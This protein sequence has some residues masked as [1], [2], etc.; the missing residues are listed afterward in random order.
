M[1][2]KSDHATPQQDGLSVSP[3]ALVMMSKQLSIK[4]KALYEVGRMS[5]PVSE[6][7]L[8]EA[9]NKVGD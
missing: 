9:G 6:L 8:V 5:E 1:L 3:I 4:C 2:N 7:G